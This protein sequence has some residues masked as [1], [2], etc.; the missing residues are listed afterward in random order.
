MVTNKSISNL[1]QNVK[2]YFTAND[3]PSLTIIRFTDVDSAQYLP[4]SIVTL[5]HAT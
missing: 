4:Q 5:F 3:V 2:Q 1:K